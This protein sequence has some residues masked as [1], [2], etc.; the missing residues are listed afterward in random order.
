MVL[1]LPADRAVQMIAVEDIGEFAAQAF[2]KPQ[3]FNGK[4]L[5][6][7]GDELIPNQFIQILSE[8]LGK[9]VKYV[10]LPIETVLQ[11]NR[12]FGLMFQWFYQYGYHANLEALKQMYPKLQNLKT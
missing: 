9:E 2:E 4:A 10:P 5:E 8:R 12:D 11:Y 1:S 6:L 3:E 7:A